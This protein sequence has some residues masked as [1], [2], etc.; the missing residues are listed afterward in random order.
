MDNFFCWHCTKA[1]P[2]TTVPGSMPRMMVP[3][4]ADEAETAIPL[5]D[6]ASKTEI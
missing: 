3:E 4:E 6:A 2:M 1:M 5:K